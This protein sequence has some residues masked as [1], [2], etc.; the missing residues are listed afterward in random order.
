MRNAAIHTD[1]FRMHG[2]GEET[3]RVSGV[4]CQKSLLSIGVHKL[5]IGNRI[6]VG[7]TR[8]THFE[9]T[10][11][12]TKYVSGTLSHPP[13]RLFLISLIKPPLSV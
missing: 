3:R 11:T 6:G 12:G 2:W 5:L 8:S 7:L 13:G 4:P 9:L 1:I 10:A